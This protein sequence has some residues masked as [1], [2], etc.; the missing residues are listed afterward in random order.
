M[1]LML[2]SKR[3][4]FYIVD[5]VIAICVICAYF[6]NSIVVIVDIIMTELLEPAARASTQETLTD[7]IFKNSIGD[8]QW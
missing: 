7:Q 1:V 3:V 6:N 8:C 2:K 5:N 4:S